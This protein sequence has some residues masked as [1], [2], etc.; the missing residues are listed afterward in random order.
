M[1]DITKETI[2]HNAPKCYF[3]VTHVKAVEAI[4]II[5]GNRV[6]GYMV[7][8]GEG[9]KVLVDKEAFESTYTPEFQVDVLAALTPKTDI[10][11]MKAIL[12]KGHKARR[13]TW[14]I[15]EYIYLV[16]AAKYPAQ[17][18]VKGVL[19]GDYPDDMIPYASYIAFKGADDVVVPYTVTQS[20]ILADDWLD[21]TED[22]IEQLVDE[23]GVVATI[24]GT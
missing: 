1:S 7:E 12:N 18:N 10:G 15:D 2:N 11:Y 13:K 9:N 20:D 5:D 8:E 19:V 3:K 23:D 17:R 21:V 14:K 24:H 22:V 6:R 16:P 4:I